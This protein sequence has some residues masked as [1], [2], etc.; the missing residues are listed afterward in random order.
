[1]AYPA[2]LHSESVVDARCRD[3]NKNKNASTGSYLQNYYAYSH[4]INY[5]QN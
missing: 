5:F 2:S 4:Q 3:G 1:M